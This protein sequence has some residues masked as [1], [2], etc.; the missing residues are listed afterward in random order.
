MGTDPE[1]LQQAHDEA[2][3]FF[4]YIEDPESDLNTVLEVEEFFGVTVP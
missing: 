1:T 3:A 4:A 2:E